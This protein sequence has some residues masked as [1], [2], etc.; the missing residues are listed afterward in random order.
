MATRPMPPTAANVQID[1]QG[2]FIRV[3]GRT[4]PRQNS[5]VRTDV[6]LNTELPEL[7]A[8]IFESKVLGRKPG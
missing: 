1:E 2:R 5:R 8:A 6:R 4:I 3:N 7:P